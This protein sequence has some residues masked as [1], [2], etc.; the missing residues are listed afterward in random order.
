MPSAVPPSR[1][2][3]GVVVVSVLERKL[4]FLLLRAYRNWDFPKGLV[5]LGES[6]IDAA[7][8]EVRE[9]TT[10][11][12]ISFDWG[13]VFMDTG[14]YSKGKIARYYIARSKETHIELPINPDLGI[15]E[16]QEARWVDYDKAQALVSP[17]LQPVLSW[18]YG[19]VNHGAS[20]AKPPDLLPRARQ[21][22]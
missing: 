2:S 21:K 20:S 5:E 8:R 9:E 19:V 7:V 4:K 10:L 16:H 6:P 17:R 13:M 1:M 22:A 3:S 15:P 11:D 14:P 18:A 12:D